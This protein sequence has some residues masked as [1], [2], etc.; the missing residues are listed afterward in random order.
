LRIEFSINGQ[1]IEDPGTLL[2]AEVPGTGIFGVRIDTT[3]DVQPLV[4]PPMTPIAP[5]DAAAPPT[6][7]TTQAVPVRSASLEKVAVD[8]RIILLR[9]LSPTGETVREI[10]LEESVLDDLPGMF[11]RLPDGHYRI[12]LKEPGEFRERLVLDVDV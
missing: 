7:D 5:L 10:P 3:P 11:S 1:P 8:E 6:L 12:Y 9:V 4:F 2:F